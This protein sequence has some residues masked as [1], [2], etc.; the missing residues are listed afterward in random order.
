MLGSTAHDRGFKV[1][2]RRRVLYSGGIFVALFLAFTAVLL[3][4]PSYVQDAG[5]EFVLRDNG[6]LENFM[7]L[8]WAAVAYEWAAR[9]W[10]CAACL[11]CCVGP[12]PPRCVVYRCRHGA[13]GDVALLGAR[14]QR[15]FLLSFGV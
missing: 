9:C 13:G 2:M 6:Y 1:M 15:H 12:F 10:C 11:A 14:L 8:W 3:T 4:S 5:G 7:T